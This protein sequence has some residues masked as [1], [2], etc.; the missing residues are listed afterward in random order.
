MT[1]QNTLQEKFSLN[2]KGLFSGLDINISFCPA[3]DN[4]GYK[5]CRTDLPGQPVITATAENVISTKRGAILSE[6]GIQVRSVKHALAALYAC[7]I[8]NCLIQ[9]DAPEFPVLDRSSAIFVNKIIQAG[10][11]E[12]AEK[13]IYYIPDH[14]IEYLDEISGSHLI[15]IPSD[16]LEIHTQIY[17][18]SEVLDLQGAIMH[19]LSEFPDEIAACRSFAFIKE[20]EFLLRKG[21]FNEDNLNNTIIVYDK[22]IHQKEL[23]KLT[24]MM[25]VEKRDAKAFGYITNTPLRFPNEPARHKII[26]II[27]DISLIGQFI[28]GIIIAI[29]P[30]HQTNNKFARLISDD[31]RNKSLP[32]CR[33]SFRN[34]PMNT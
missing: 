29:C 23:D 19:N 21:L 33:S 13:R 30:G 27:G 9:V 2:G 1:K 8:D 18:D 26:D 12:Q 4:F 7:G 14:K 20:I 15:L 17:Y 5:I 25:N 6:N 10:I 3:A 28:K 11:R 24:R 34:I 32:K 31:I 16:K 22:Q